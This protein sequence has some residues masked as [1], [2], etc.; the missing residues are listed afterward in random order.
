[1]DTKEL[2]GAEGSRDKRRAALAHALAQEVQTVPPQRLM[3]LL[4]DAL[5]WCALLTSCLLHMYTWCRALVQTATSA[6]VPLPARLPQ[7]AQ[8]LACAPMA[9]PAGA[10]LLGRRI[11]LCSVLGNAPAGSRRLAARAEL[12]AMWW[13][14]YG[15]VNHLRARCTPCI[16][17]HD[18][19]AR[20]DRA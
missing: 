14:Q 8:F 2:Y 3:A 19:T 7:P 13:A 15:R 10:R 5:R 9:S 11:V 20:D 1:M 18:V 17:M 6:G 12:A 4:S 16:R